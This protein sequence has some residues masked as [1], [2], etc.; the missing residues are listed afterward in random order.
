M[1]STS[2]FIATMGMVVATIATTIGAQPPG[3][4]PGA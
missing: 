2:Y 1:R 3:P 4:P